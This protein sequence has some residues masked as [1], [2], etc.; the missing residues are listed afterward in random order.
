MYSALAD[1]GPDDAFWSVV[2]DYIVRVAN[3]L[4]RQRYGLA[5]PDYVDELQSVSLIDTFLSISRFRPIKGDTSFSRWIYGIVRLRARR[6]ARRRRNDRLIPMSQLEDERE[7]CYP[8]DIFGADIPDPVLI[9]ERFDRLD[10]ID[11]M[12]DRMRSLL[13]GDDLIMF[14]LLRAG[15]TVYST[16]K[17]MGL[18]RYCVSKR[19]T[20]WRRMA[21]A[22]HIYP[23]GYR[24]M[25]RAHLRAMR[26]YRDKRRLL[27]LT[28]LSN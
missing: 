7:E 11:L 16:C 22:A 14:D 9:D 5:N 21:L 4:V 6:L 20:A 2:A 25:D 8:D 17:L 10:Q 18:Q 24:I 27:G 13:A 15:H 26:K 3:S 12:L 19:M 23:E 1:S 28:K